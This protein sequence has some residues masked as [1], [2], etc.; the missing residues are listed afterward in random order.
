MFA[1]FVGW[2]EVAGRGGARNYP[3]ADVDPFELGEALKQYVR[4]T[5]LAR[6]FALSPYGH[7]QRSSA[8]SGRGLVKAQE[9]IKACFQVEETLQFKFTTLKDALAVGVHNFFGDDIG[10]GRAEWPRK[11]AETMLTI[12]AHARRLKDETRFREA[13]SK[14]TNHERK[15]L[16]EVRAM[17]L[18][19]AQEEEER[20]TAKLPISKEEEDEEEKAKKLSK[21]EKEKLPEEE[22]DE[23]ARA[24]NKRKK[25]KEQELQRIRSM[26]IPAT[27]S[28][29]DAWS[30]DANECS[31]VPTKKRALKDAIFIKKK[32]A[33]KDL[34]DERKAAKK[35]AAEETEDPKDEGKAAKKADAE[36]AEDLTTTG[37]AA[38]EKAKPTK[39]KK[40]KN[41]G[42]KRTRYPPMASLTKDQ[43]KKLIIMDYKKICAS[44]LRVIQV[45]TK[46]FQDARTMIEKLLKDHVQGQSNILKGTQ[47]SARSYLSLVYQNTQG[48][49]SYEDWYEWV[50]EEYQTIL[51]ARRSGPAVVPLAVQLC[52]KMKGWPAGLTSKASAPREARVDSRAAA[53]RLKDQQEHG[54]RLPD[55]KASKPLQEVHGN[56]GILQALMLEEHGPETKA[57]K[58]LQEDHGM[59]T[60]DSKT[61]K[62]RE[63]HAEILETKAST[64]EDHGMDTPDTKASKPRE[65]HGP[66]LPDS[67]ASKPLQEEQHGGPHHLQAKASNA[68]EEEHGGPHHGH[69]Q[70]KASNALE[71]LPHL[72]TM[73]SK[74]MEEV[75]D[76][77]IPASGVPASLPKESGTK[78]FQDARTM[79]EKLLKDARTMIEKLL[80]ELKN[81]KSLDEIRS[82]KARLLSKR[83]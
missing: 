34:K 6:S 8:V 43:V 26:E 21:K 69:L 62:P 57:S 32:P 36:E 67:K 65:E 79:I 31:P 18:G 17:I 73:G 64:L 41:G 60:P 42:K 4:T 28:V 29:F 23:D 75:P 83:C 53:R 22:D 40:A 82:M 24:K 3:K 14:L 66:H 63:D 47:Q 30:Q 7:L 1:A 37:A 61:S 51:D 77:L 15:M 56:I 11:T 70:A 59:D 2:R 76:K 33:A 49:Q 12:F 54:P 16:T 19:T 74:A 72:E 25:E 13:C 48:T 55:S 80:K 38:A 44:A 9:L 20:K 39:N 81:G 27:P 71:D 50:V 5:G 10:G 45:K 68:L 52:K 46:K 35:A 78:K 58:P